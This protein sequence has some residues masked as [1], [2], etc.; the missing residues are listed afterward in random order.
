LL[1][2]TWKDGW[3]II[4]EQGKDIPYQHKA[5]AIKATTITPDK[6]SGN[7][8]WQDNFSSNTLGFEWVSLRS[9]DSPFYRLTKSGIQLQALN[10]KLDSLAQPAFLGRR[11]Q[12]TRF[13]A[14]ATF[15]LPDAKTSAGIVALQSETAH[16]YFG[17]RQ[18]ENGT[19][20]FIEQAHKKAP[21]LV[22]RKVINDLVLP[23]NLRI[24]G[25]AGKIRFSYKNN[26]GQYTAVLKEADAKILSTEVA[27]GFVGT[28]LG[29][30]ARAE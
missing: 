11:Q 14:S 8:T 19:E 16:Y 12:H 29:I 22:Y 21:A 20:L 10:I 1:P 28:L 30:H 4:L 18:T 13:N 15:A 25:D 3:P 2:V 27:G 24:E 9:A 6:L 17:V 23:I 7:F 26:K 5:P